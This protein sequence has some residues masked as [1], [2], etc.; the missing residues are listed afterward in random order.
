MELRFVEREEIG[1]KDTGRIIRVLQYREEE[2]PRGEEWWGEWQDV[3][4]VKL[5]DVYP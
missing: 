1:T 5:E 4:L 3:P 2:G